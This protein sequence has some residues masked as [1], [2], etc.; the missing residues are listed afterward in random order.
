MTYHEKFDKFY[1]SK[2]WKSLRNQKFSDA[3]GLC[4]MCYKDGI[5]RQGREVHHKVP[6]EKNW[7][8]RLDYDNLILLCPEHHQQMHD[9]DSQLQKFL[10]EWENL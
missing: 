7:N 1:N 6:I 8:K 4:E 3:N 2:E 5:I 9:R 10:R